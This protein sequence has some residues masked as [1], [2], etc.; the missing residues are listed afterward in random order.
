MLQKGILA[1]IVQKVRIALSTD[2][3]LV[4]LVF[5]IRVHWIAIYPMDSAIHLLNNRGLKYK[6]LDTHLFS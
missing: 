3:A 2:K 5:L 1:P 6:T 4:Q